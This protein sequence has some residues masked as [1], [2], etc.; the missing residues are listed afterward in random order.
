METFGRSQ[1][2]GQET[3]PQHS[4]TVPQ[5]AETVPQHAE[6]VPQHAETVPQHAETVPQHVGLC[7]YWLPHPRLAIHD[8]HAN[9]KTAR[10]GSKST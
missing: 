7:N 4:E 9:V 6:T 5:H 3:M 2:H 1:W 8:S 10:C